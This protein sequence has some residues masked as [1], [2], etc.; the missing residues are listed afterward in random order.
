MPGRSPTR[1]SG[2]GGDGLMSGAGIGPVEDDGVIV[3]HAA[4][5]TTPTPS[6]TESNGEN[7]GFT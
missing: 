2:L 7:A 1:G 6:V 5:N 3:A 4:A